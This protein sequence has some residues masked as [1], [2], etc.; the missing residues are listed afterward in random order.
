M[1][2]K[3]FIKNFTSNSPKKKISLSKLSLNKNSQYNYKSQNRKKNLISKDSKMKSIQSKKLFNNCIKKPSNTKNL[4]KIT[5]NSKKKKSKNKKKNFNLISQ[6]EKFTPIN[7]NSNN[8]V[9]NNS[10]KSNY[11]DDRMLRFIHQNKYS[12][13]QSGVSHS[14][15]SS[16]FLINNFQL[17]KGGEQLSKS[18]LE[19]NSKQSK[20]SS[21]INKQKLNYSHKK[22]KSSK[23]ITTVN[24]KTQNMTNYTSNK[25]SKCTSQKN[26][27]KNLHS[28]KKSKKN[29]QISHPFNMSENIKPKISKKSNYYSNT[30]SKIKNT[31]I[32]CK[33]NIIPT[34]R[35]K[36]EHIKSK[37][38]SKFF[39]NRNFLNLFNQKSYLTLNTDKENLIDFK[40]KLTEKNKTPTFNY[41]MF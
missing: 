6:F 12:Q 23:F 1:Y 36:S 35:N 32:S 14:F 29:L 34:K 25:K 15:D 28:L 7:S 24:K 13:N 3:S 10:P 9:F 11:K 21:Y 4:K 38:S 18:K 16:S 40:K 39:S 8:Q 37:K 22:K 5:I 19:N 30:S 33:T 41:Q 27:C 20:I 31:I 2:N 17:T 26:S